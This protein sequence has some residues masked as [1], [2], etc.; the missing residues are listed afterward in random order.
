MANRL[1]DELAALL[2]DTI[3]NIHQAPEAHLLT[4]V[5]GRLLANTATFRNILV[6][7]REYDEH[8]TQII[9]KCF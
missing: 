4:W 3:F 6:P 2:G 9:R 5:G 7:R 8:G 1:R